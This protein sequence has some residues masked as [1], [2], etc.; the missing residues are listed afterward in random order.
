[1][2]KFEQWLNWWI[3]TLSFIVFLAI[4]AA[5]FYCWYLLIT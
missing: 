2:K 5:V 1:M 4:E 3:V